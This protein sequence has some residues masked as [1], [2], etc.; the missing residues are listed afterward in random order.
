MSWHCHLHFRFIVI[1]LIF[2]IYFL[3]RDVGIEPTHR[4][5]GDL[6]DTLSVSHILH[7]RRDSNPHQS[8]D[9][10]R[11][12]GWSRLVTPMSE[13]IKTPRQGSGR[14]WLFLL[15]YFFYDWRH[16]SNFHS[17]PGITSLIG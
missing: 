13:C 11:R 12:A 7:T 5:F 4:G 16:I 10:F 9:P 2:L 14:I 1:V 15:L 6:T 3:A 17:E 8:L